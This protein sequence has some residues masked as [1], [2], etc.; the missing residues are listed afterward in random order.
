LDGFHGLTLAQAFYDFAT[1]NTIAIGSTINAS[2]TTLIETAPGVGVPAEAGPPPIVQ[3]L[4]LTVGQD[5]VATGQM[6]DGVTVGG[7]NTNTAI[8]AP[9][10]GVFG[11]QPTL[12]PADSIVL[13]SG[14]NSLSATFDGTFLDSGLTIQGVQ[15]VSVQNVDIFGGSIVTLFGTPGSID[16]IN[17]LTYNDDLFGNSLV[18]GLPT[19][20][21]DATSGASDFALTVENALGDGI[22]PFDHNVTVWFAPAALAG[23]TDTI[24]VTANLVGDTL[25]GLSQ[26]PFHAYSIV[27]GSATNGFGTWDVTSEGAL[28]A[29]TANDIALGANGSTAATTLNI[30]DDGSTTILWASF[31][32]GSHGSA[33]WANLAVINAG[34]TTGQLTIS[35]GEFPGAGLLADNGDSINTVVGGS[36]ADLFDLS[37]SDWSIVGGLVVDKNGVDVTIN[38][39]GDPLGGTNIFG[40]AGTGVELNNSEINDISGVASNAFEQW[41]GVNILYDASTDTGGAVNMA[42]FPGTDTVTL[43][44]SESL[45]FDIFQEADFNVTNAPDGFTFNFNDTDQFGENFSVI[46]TDTTGGAANVVTIN[47]TTVAATGTFTSQNFDTVNV[48]VNDVNGATQ[49]FYSGSFV[50]DTGAPVPF[51][52]PDILVIGNA[53]FT[54]PVGQGVTL[55]IEANGDFPGSGTLTIGNV[56]SGLIGDDSIT[57]LSGPITGL[58]LHPS[59]LDTGTLDISGTANVTIGVT[60]ADVITSTT[61]GIFDMTSPGDANAPG[62][63]A[64]WLPYD[65]V[66]VSSVSGFSTLQGTL[67]SA[68][69]FKGFPILDA[70]NDSLTDTAGG[71]FFLGD[72]GSD[73]ITLGNGAFEANSVFFGEFELNDIAARQPIENDGVA[74]D[75]FWGAG[76]SLFGTTITGS[77][78][79]D[80]TTVTG[81][82]VGNDNLVFN[83]NAW[84]GGNTHGD[85][86]DGA[87]VTKISDTTASGS[88]LFLGT[89]GLTLG[90][91]PATTASGHVDLIL[92]GI[93]NQSF[94]NA[95]ELASS[96]GTTGV[97]NFN[98]GH[99]L[100]NNGIIDLL[101]AYFNGS[102]VVIADVELQNHSGGAT[103]NTGAMTVFASDMVS[104][105]GVTSLASL[106]TTANALHIE[107][108][109]V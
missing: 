46:G 32:G 11:N 88:T 29:G 42:D 99:T 23:D 82:S 95:G 87:A 16:G 44:N 62:T 78:S 81:F 48:N 53:D 63:V 104:L 5:T 35:G 59:Y 50:D 41:T 9:L 27:A 75:G 15:S 57:L 94:A 26:D 74:A 21:I 10:G 56:S 103:A 8:S 89:S 79:D 52:S 36:G 98:L 101:V 66:D 6:F 108:A 1:S 93:N 86:D 37:S 76:P 102:N 12:T 91:A 55:N 18:V 68:G 14:D 7:T 96:I 97:G 69:T 30:T 34:D 77:T 100:A 45:P 17:S 43:V 106:G 31:A 22:A 80:L 64:E 4:T 25:F 92:D 2:I 60:N 70:G 20:G 105:V 67:G 49:T 65:G 13:T 24:S 85:L 54:A 84:S 72:G 109:H 61:S 83:V 71:T 107:F 58:P 38:G 51:G 40:D 28:V 19:A 3:P 73:S 39:G 33:D 47:Y 90:T